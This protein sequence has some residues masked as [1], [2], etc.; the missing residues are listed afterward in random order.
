MSRNKGQ[1][2]FKASP[3]TPGDAP[4]GYAVVYLRCQRIDRLFGCIV[5]DNAS[6]FFIFIFNNDLT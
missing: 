2:V 3:S 1:V 4:I 6:D 5:R